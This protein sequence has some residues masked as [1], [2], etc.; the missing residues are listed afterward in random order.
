[1]R[2]AI[3]PNFQ[4]RLEAAG[5]GIA[6]SG[7]SRQVKIFGPAF[8]ASYGCRRRSRRMRT[9]LRFSAQKFSSSNHYSR[10]VKTFMTRPSTLV[11]GTIPT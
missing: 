8:R 3:V 9:Q 10:G 4:S 5:V 6:D 1:M 7:Q 2:G 11:L